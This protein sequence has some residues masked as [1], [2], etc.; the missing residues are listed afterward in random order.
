MNYKTRSYLRVE[1]TGKVSRTAEFYFASF[2]TW[3]RY[4]KDHPKSISS[5]FHLNSIKPSKP[6][7]FLPK[8]WRA[9]TEYK[10]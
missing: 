8:T 1:M 10:V 3:L 6:G 9:E 5:I 7:G 2:P 4:Q